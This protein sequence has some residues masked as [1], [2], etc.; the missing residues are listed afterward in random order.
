MGQKPYLSLVG[1]GPHK[2][3][4]SPGHSAQIIIGQNYY[5]SL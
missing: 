3:L 4:G 2:T 5:P 1:L